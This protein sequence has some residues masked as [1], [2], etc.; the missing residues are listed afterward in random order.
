MRFIV[1]KKAGIIASLLVAIALIIVALPVF[2]NVSAA[3]L[4]FDQSVRKVPIYSVETTSNKVG[5]SFDA[6]WGADKTQAIVDLLK[7]RKVNATFFLVGFWAEE[8][9]DLVKKIDEAGFEIGLHSNSHPDFKKLTEEQIKSELL[10]N[11]AILEKILGKKPTLFRFPFGSYNDKAIKICEDLGLTCVQWDVDSLDWKG[12]SA[13]DISK[14]V[15][16]K[17]KSGSLCLF[18]NNSDNI[19]DALPLVLDGLKNKGFEVTNIGDVLHKD[20][21]VIDRNGIQKQVKK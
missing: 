19:L 9:Q 14:R 20:N 17:A 5:I 15:L 6:A 4:F 3:G 13:L 1:L 16:Q 18:H 8:H 11:I 12:I 7:D 10:S 2:N 21:F